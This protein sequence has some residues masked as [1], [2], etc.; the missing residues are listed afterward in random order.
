MGHFYIKG[1]RWKITIKAPFIFRSYFP[2]AASE[3]SF[4]SVQLVIL[5]S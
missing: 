2:C 3:T 4:H 1:I 5:S